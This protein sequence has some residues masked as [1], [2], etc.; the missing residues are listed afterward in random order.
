MCL[1]AH[2]LSAHITIAYIFGKDFL[3]YLDLD[4]LQ[5]VKVRD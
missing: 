1:G 2:N 5:V 4:L 3:K